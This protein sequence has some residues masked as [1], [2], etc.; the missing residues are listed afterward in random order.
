[1]GVAGVQ[2][3]GSEDF[4]DV[5]PDVALRYGKHQLNPAFQVAGH[6]VGAGQIQL[7]G[8]PALAK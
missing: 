4:Q 8:S 5:L 7:L 2:K 3:V 1:V 6:P